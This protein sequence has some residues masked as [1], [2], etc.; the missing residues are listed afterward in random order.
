MI[1]NGFMAVS[2]GANMPS[3]PKAMEAFK[4]VGVLFGPAKA[5]GMKG[6]LAASANIAGFLKVQMP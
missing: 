4:K 5:H 2:E 1:Q 6:D 3:T